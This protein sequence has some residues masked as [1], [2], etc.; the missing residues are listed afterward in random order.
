MAQAVENELDVAGLLAKWHKRLRESQF[1]HYAAAESFS[2]RNTMF[3]LPVVIL[4]AIVGS[5]AIIGSSAVASSGAAWP[6]PPPWLSALLGCS[7]LVAGVLAAIQTYFGFAEKSEKHRAAGARYGAI[8]R[9]VEQAQALL[10]TLGPERLVETLDTI[11]EQID[12]LAD[13]APNVSLRHRK[14]AERTMQ[15]Q[16]E[17]AIATASR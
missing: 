3:G 16:D 6:W 14:K 12:A 17:L 13:E 2:A 7:S 11:R 1:S 9:H 5:T 4:S 15:A 8:R 10:K